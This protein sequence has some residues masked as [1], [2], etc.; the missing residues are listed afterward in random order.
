MRLALREG[1]K[2]R[3]R[4]HPNPCVGAV[5]VRAGHVVGRGF[6]RRAGLPHAEVEAIRQAGRAARGAD[7][8]VTLEPCAHTGRTPPCTEAILQAGVRR[9]FVGAVDPNPLVHGRGIAKLRRAGAEVAVDVL[10][11]ECEQAHRAFFRHVT[12]GRPLVVLKAAA[13]ADGKIATATGDSRW[14]TG[15]TARELVHRWR[16]EFDAV[17]AGAGTVAKDDPLLTTRLAR[18]AVPGREPRTALRVIL[19][20]RGRPG[21]DA[22][23]FDT[24]AGPVLLATADA[25]SARVRA[26]AACGV[27][28]VSLPAGEAGVD[29][30]ALLDELGRRGITSVLVEG[31]AA[32]FGALLRAGLADEVRLFVA[33]KLA[34][35]EGLSWAGALGIGAM[36]DAMRLEDVRLEMVGEDLLIRARPVPLNSGG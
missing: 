8:Y 6:H 12:T 4:T 25:A 34:G 26:I 16:D 1:E 29:V 21:P 15:E 5:I 14:V 35:A 11:V 23:V 2:G 24:S 10:R 32:V 27:E 13:T 19:D 31:G 17:L 20:G 33:P 7:L 28:I 18:P 36:A 30:A 22:K 9:V 3:G